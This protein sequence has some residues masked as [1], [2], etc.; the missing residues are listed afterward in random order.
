MVR[1]VADVAQHPAF[2]ASEVERVRAN[3]LRDLA[4]AR[5]Q[6][7]NLALDR[8][9]AAL[10][11]GHAYGRY[12][13]DPAVV[14]GFSLEQVRRFYGATFGAAR[15]HLYVTGRFDPAAVEAAVREA[16]GGWAAG[17]PAAFAPP[18]P[19]A[20]RALYVID[21]PGAVQSTI[22]IGLPTIDPSNPDYVP[23]TVAN[24]LLGGA[25][26]SRI[27]SNIREAKGYTYSPFSALTARLRDA[28][29]AEVADVTTA[30]TGPALTEILKEIDRLAK[31]P[32]AADELRGIQNYLAGT[33]VLRNSSRT[34]LATQ[35]EFVDLHGLGE[36]YLRSYVR[37]I[38]AVTPE[39]VTRVT[40]RYLRGADMTIVVA[41]DRKVIDQQLKG[42]GALLQ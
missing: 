25:F 12:L 4:I 39:E 22:Y 6:Q 19:K 10:Y 16:F 18:T 24:A 32:P 27:T 9:R 29:W 30:V 17:T 8:F 13:A 15:A 38:Y 3:A 42:F 7:Q 20:G 5:S 28:Y 14:Q 36:D 41:G 31:E 35:F 34:G 37:R 40:Q 2:P 23:L 1:L 26:A 21:R 11:P 33:F